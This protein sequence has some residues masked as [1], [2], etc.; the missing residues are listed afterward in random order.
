MSAYNQPLTCL[1]IYNPSNIALRAKTLE[2]NF[3][4]FFVRGHSCNNVIHL[5][6]RRPDCWHPRRSKRSKI[7]TV[8]RWDNSFCRAFTSPTHFNTSLCFRRPLPRK[9][10]SLAP[11]STASPRH[12]W[13]DGCWC[14]MTGGL[15]VLCHC[16]PFLLFFFFFFFSF[17][18]RCSAVA[19]FQ[20]PAL[21][22]AQPFLSFFALF[23]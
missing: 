6:N 12:C 18:L 14:K 21:S 17:V 22:I 19:A 2:R 10:A 1:S 5:R 11:L 15:K 9:R 3:G 16:F 7:I 8:M 4:L 23:R 13:R 20:Q